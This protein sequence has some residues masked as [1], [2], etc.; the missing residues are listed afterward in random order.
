MFDFNDIGIKGPEDLQE[1][2][3]VEMTP[4]MFKNQFTWMVERWGLDSCLSML[5][6]ALFGNEELKG[7]IK[8]NK[9][10]VPYNPKDPGTEYYLED[11]DEEENS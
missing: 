5:G 4:E 11:I 9:R 6:H 3:Q 2:L 8:P 10:F 7:L 1:A